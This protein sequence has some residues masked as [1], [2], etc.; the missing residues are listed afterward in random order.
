MIPKPSSPTFDSVFNRYA[1]FLVFCVNCGK[2]F[3][4]FRKGRM[5][6]LYPKE[7]R[8]SKAVSCSDKCQ[9]QF[10]EKNFGRRLI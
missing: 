10:N 7:I 6:K 5:T 3:P 1:T 2:P 4:R 8:H 9:K